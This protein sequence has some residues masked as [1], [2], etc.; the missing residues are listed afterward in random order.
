M[1]LREY[2]KRQLD[3]LV[4]HEDCDEV[5]GLESPTGSGKSF[6]I[7]NYITHLFNRHENL[8]V[9]I[10]TGSNNL[11][12]EFA[13]TAKKWGLDPIIMVGNNLLTCYD[14][15]DAGQIFSLNQDNWCST[16]KKN[17]K[18]K[19]AN[20]KLVLCDACKRCRYPHLIST[21]AKINDFTKNRLIITNHQAFL[22]H[23]FG[24][25]MYHPDVVIVD[26]AHLFST[27][28]SNWKNTEITKEDID[29]IFNCLKG[30]PQEKLFEIFLEKGDPIP[31]QLAIKICDLIRINYKAL[32]ELKKWVE[33]LCSRIEQFTEKKSNEIFYDINKQHMKKIIFW[34]HY[35]IMQHSIKYRLFSATLDRFT[36]MMFGMDPDRFDYFYKERNLNLI[37]YT[38]S[39]AYIYKLNDFNVALNNFI[40][41]CEERQFK[42][43]L[44]LSTTLE[45]VANLKKQGKVGK[46]TVYTALKDFRE[47]KGYKVLVGS[48]ALFQGIDI[49]TIQFV[50]LNKIPF[51]QY[52]EEFKMKVNYLNTTIG[53]D[54]WT[55][56]SIPFVNNT[57]IQT[58][59]RLWRGPDDFGLVA[60]SDSR[61]DGRFS[62]LLKNITEVRKGINL[63]ILYNDEEENTEGFEEIVRDVSDDNCN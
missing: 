38:K 51:E 16:I 53:I 9:V 63:H 39:D 62:Y 49:P 30:K 11:V 1:E 17:S 48:R 7:V 6:V 12:F 32:P 3:F 36:R 60:I 50:M 35:D 29:K 61:L 13:A 15:K 2:Q 31:Q 55:D 5:V 41:K 23:V 44:I 20:G 45:N 4:K 54:P 28:Y 14:N 58:T 43:G 52:D 18:V 22:S 46:Y 27:F 19:D 24:S 56:Y 42:Q 40:K 57:M 25:G 37:D 10:T 47:A 59:G 26:E 34:N 33:N 8:N 21:K